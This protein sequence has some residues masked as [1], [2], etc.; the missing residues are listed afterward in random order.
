MK[1]PEENFLADD[2]RAA[3]NA[4]GQ[5]LQQELGLGVGIYFVHV[6]S[7]GEEGGRQCRLAS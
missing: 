4:R 2:R 5:D 7:E 1:V 3:D 6:S